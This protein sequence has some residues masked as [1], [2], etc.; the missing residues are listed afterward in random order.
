MMRIAGFVAVSLLA[1]IALGQ[2]GPTV[3]M[4][5][6]DVIEGITFDNVKG[7]VFV[8]IDELATELGVIADWDPKAKSFVIGEKVLATKDVRELFDGTPIIN[9]LAL[10]GE[11]FQVEFD[12]LTEDYKVMSSTHFGVVTIPD[13]WVEVNL[14]SQRLRGYQGD[15][16]VIDTKIS[17]GKKGNSTPTGEFKTGPEKS[18]YRTSSKYENA[19]MPFSVQ[20]YGGYFIHG[21]SSV[22]SYPASHGCIRMPLTGMNAAKYFFEWVSL[23]VPVTLNYGWSARIT[24]LEAAAKG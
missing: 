13:Q 24:K 19:P 2:R 1:G 4:P 14:A 3:V 11:G 12:T 17:S 10:K 18:K 6:E 9:I 5:A 23:K 22:P 20:F 16:L 15:R 7:A 21:S 8:P